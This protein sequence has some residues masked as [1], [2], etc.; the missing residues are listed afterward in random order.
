V[1]LR[2][3]LKNALCLQGTVIEKVKRSDGSLL[4]HVRPTK[5]AS[6]RCSRCLK[7]CSTHGRLSTGRRWRSMDLGCTRVYLEGCTYRVRC[8]EHGVVVAHVPWA[9]PGSRFT[10]A[11]VELAA[12][13]ATHSPK[14]TVAEFLGTTWRSVGSAIHR[15]LSRNE[16]PIH[17]LPLRVIGIDEISYRKGQRYITVIVDH[18]SGRL[19]WAA[20]G[21]GK[22]VLHQFFDILGPDRCKLIE[23]V[24]RDS[25]TWISTVIDERCPQAHQCMDPFHVVQWATKAV[26]KVRRSTWWNSKYWSSSTTYR[27][28]KG[29]HWILRRSAEDLTEIQA[30]GLALI[31]KENRPLYRAYL[32]KEQLRLIFRLPY[33]DA[34]RLLE[35]W[36]VWARRSKI[37]QFREVAK[38][39]VREQAA[40]EATLRYRHTNARV[41]AI[42]TSLRL[43]VRQA[44]GFHSAGPMITLA[45][46]KHGGLCPPLPGRT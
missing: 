40:I 28:I 42:N 11:F 1:G 10:T 21:T 7:R 9:H 39:I 37:P 23:F 17:T 3:I 2:R 15:C 6:R 33:N 19:L 38:S 41:E 26:E 22:A 14:D 27:N 29:A 36:L 44:Y 13:L 32:L 18:E 12:W 4:L 5:G 16:W 34:I 35:R 31:Q 24:T 25:A 30:E 43:I 45:M 46:L 20:P 8:P